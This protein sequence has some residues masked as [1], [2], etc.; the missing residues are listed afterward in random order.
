[1]K[2][3]TLIVISIAAVVLMSAGFFVRSA[4]R[5]PGIIS[6]VFDI[7]QPRVTSI[8]SSTQ[9]TVSFSPPRKLRIPAI[10][11]DAIVEH[12]GLADDGRMGIPVDSMNVAWYNLGF[13]PGEQGN[14]VVA[15]HVDLSNGD[16]SV[17]AD[18]D[19]LNSGDTIE[20]VDGEGNTLTFRVV[21][22]KIFEDAQFP[23]KDVFG[24]SSVPRL[25]LITCD[26]V[27]DKQASN[28]SHRL[29]IFSELVK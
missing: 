27:Y 6:G 29:V 19:I 26:G 15:G 10:G 9:E 23:T 18:I 16:P 22:K 7:S 13:V 20:V 11:V 3:R 2:T 8:P 1:M 25:N 17:F 14:A 21:D 28:Y 4:A 24:E 12:V 5:E